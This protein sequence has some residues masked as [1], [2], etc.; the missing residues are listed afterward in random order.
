[1]TPTIRPAEPGDA[2]QIAAMIHALADFE[3]AAEHCTLTETQIRA[4]LFDEPT[5]LRAHVAE[6]DGQVA[7]TATWFLNFAT[8]DGVPGIYVEDLYVLPQFR[9]H[10]LARAL[11]SALARVCVDNGY[12]RLAWAVLNWNCDAIALYD[13]IGGKPQREWT[14]YRVSGPALAELAGPR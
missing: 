6:V 13:A 8:W 3:R 11:L 14:T 2:A 5:T 10:G 9:R 12:T 4:A 1:M 7:A